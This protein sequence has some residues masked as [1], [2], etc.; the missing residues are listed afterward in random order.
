[1]RLALLDQ[2]VQDLGLW[3]RPGVS[4]EQRENLVQEVFRNITIDGRDFVSIE[5]RPPYV[6]LFATMVADQQ[7]GYREPKSPPPPPE[8]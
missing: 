7:L 5:P 2:E 6:P 4:H 8:N 1:M 3:L